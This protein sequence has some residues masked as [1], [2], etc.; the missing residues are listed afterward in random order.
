MIGL[1][2]NAIGI[3][4]WCYLQKQYHFG[5]I[6]NTPLISGGWHNPALSLL[7]KGRVGSMGK[8]TQI[9][10]KDRKLSVGY[11]RIDIR[12]HGQGRI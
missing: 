6:L 1:A 7:S 10:Q 4:L 12:R 8:P 2:G 3:A 11:L 5:G 9:R